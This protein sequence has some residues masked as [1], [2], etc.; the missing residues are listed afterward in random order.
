M[1]S[2]KIAN[3]N[4]IQVNDGTNNTIRDM[5]SRLEIPKN[6]RQRP[7]AH[8]YAHNERIVGNMNELRKQRIRNYPQTIPDT[9]ADIPF[10][11]ILN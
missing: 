2:I 11:L 9:F 7:L 8:I 5:M 10:L 6:P 4:V 1:N 3:S